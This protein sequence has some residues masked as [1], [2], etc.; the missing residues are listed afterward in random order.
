MRP[1]FLILLLPL[2]PALC[3][4]FN[5]HP[6]RGLAFALSYWE[7]LQAFPVHLEA[8]ATGQS[9]HRFIRKAVD[10]PVFTLLPEGLETEGQPRGQLAME[11][12]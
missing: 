9:S 8:L 6:K 10:H 5:L 12:Q 2:L 7:V 11:S 3:K 1:I 4:G